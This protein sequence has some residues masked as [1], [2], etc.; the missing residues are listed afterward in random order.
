MGKGEKGKRG[1]GEKEKRGKG[2]KGERGKGKWGK[3]KSARGDKT[4]REK[5][6]MQKLIWSISSRM[7]F[8]IK[9][10]ADGEFSVVKTAIARYLK[11]SNSAAADF[12]EIKDSASVVAFGTKHL[13]KPSPKS[14]IQE[15]VFHDIRPEI[16]LQRKSSA[17]DKVKT[18]AGISTRY[19]YVCEVS[20][21]Y[22]S[23]RRN[24]I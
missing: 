11:K 16:F 13:S 24:I 17:L 1:K 18:L 12:V 15:R 14:G 6:K 10:T 19:Q 3:Y 7:H 22:T 8:I 21:F 2:E 20:N 4:S 23:E 5:G 9:D